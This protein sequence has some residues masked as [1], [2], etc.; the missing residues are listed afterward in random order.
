MAAN[1]SIVLPGQG[2]PVFMVRNLSRP[3]KRKKRVA[4]ELDNSVQEVRS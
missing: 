2:L 4:K 1:W 3:A